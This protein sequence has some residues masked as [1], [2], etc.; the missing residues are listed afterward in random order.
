M[1]RCILSFL[2]TFALA[3]L[4]TL[5]AADAQPRGKV[6]RIGFLGDGSAASQAVY[7]LEPFREGLREL[8][9]V[10]GQNVLLEV[11]WTDGKNQIPPDFVVNL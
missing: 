11:R 7:T 2:I 5:P 8:G 9:Y 4:V 10:E 3:L 1:Q 6:P